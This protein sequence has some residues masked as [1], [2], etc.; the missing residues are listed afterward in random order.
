MDQ[1]EAVASYCLEEI[2]GVQTDEEEEGPFVEN[3]AV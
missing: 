3:R 2:R 1:E